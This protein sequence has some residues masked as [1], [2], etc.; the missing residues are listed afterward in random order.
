[1]PTA[2]ISKTTTR[3]LK[4]VNKWWDGT[5]INKRLTKKCKWLYRSATYDTVQIK[6]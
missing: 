5:R 1:M 6:H 3:L 2:V 4:E